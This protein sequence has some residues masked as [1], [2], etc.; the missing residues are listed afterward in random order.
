M[1]SKKQ[2][3]ANA[4]KITNTALRASST[5][6]NHSSGGARSRWNNAEGQRAARLAEKYGE[7]AALAR[8][9]EIVLR[10]ARSPDRLPAPGPRV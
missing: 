3:N 6:A 1:F 8:Y 5:R 7:G 10:T 9:R 4:P 2:C